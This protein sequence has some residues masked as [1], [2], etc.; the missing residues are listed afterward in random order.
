LD[1]EHRLSDRRF[2][3]LPAPAA[4]SFLKA[5]ALALAL[6]VFTDAGS[7]AQQANPD[8]R[9][10]FAPRKNT[11]PPKQVKQADLSQQDKADIARI[12]TYF[13]SIRTLSGRFYQISSLGEIAEGKIYLSRPGKLRIEYNPPVPILIIADG[14]KLTYYDSELKSINTFRIEATP[15][16][17]LLRDKLD[18]GTDIE[19]IGFDRGKGVIRLTILD[20]E[21]PDIGR[22]TLVFADKPLSLKK[23]IVI[24]PQGVTTTVALLD[25]TT[26]MELKPHLFAFEHPDGLY[27]PL[28]K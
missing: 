12:E 28:I 1:L 18:L 3:L 9:R 25:T 26:G 11:T 22:L 24:D 5:V 20:K 8:Q 10:S 15:A 4:W 2:F 21:N 19:V 6:L 7:Q 23:W 14:Q 27:N 13:D 17:I 16:Y